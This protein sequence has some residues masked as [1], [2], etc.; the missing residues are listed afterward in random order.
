MFYI[1]LTVLLWKCKRYKYLDDIVSASKDVGD[2]Q[3]D[4][5]FGEIKDRTDFTQ[6]KNRHH[7]LDDRDT[8]VDSELFSE[9][10]GV[11]TT[12]TVI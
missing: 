4:G 8:Q 6:V 10:L 5:T 12:E 2:I 1:A 9:M 11:A 7:R 3:V